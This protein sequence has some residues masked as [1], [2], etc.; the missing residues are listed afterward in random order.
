MMLVELE[1]NAQMPAAWHNGWAG[2]GVID[3][4]VEVSGVSSTEGSFLLIE[5][6]ARHVY[7]AGPKGGSLIVFF[8]SGRAAYP[9]WDSPSA[10]Q[11]VEIS[12]ALRLP[13]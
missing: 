3:G 2:V 11:V 6:T 5:P 7:Q 4:T 10:P 1:P 12:Q 9:V 8:D 13:S